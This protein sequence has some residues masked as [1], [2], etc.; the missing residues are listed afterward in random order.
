MLGYALMIV[1]QNFAQNRARTFRLGAIV[2]LSFSGNS[3]FYFFQQLVLRHL[4]RT[5]NWL[6]DSYGRCMILKELNHWDD[7]I[8]YLNANCSH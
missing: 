7:K 2:S 5:N 8:K 6:L 4:W 1:I 3:K